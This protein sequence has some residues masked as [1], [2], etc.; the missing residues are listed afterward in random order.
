MEVLTLLWRESSSQRREKMDTP[1]KILV[2]ILTIAILFTCCVGGT[3]GFMY[4][5]NHGWFEIALGIT[6][7]IASETT[8]V[9]VVEATS[10]PCEKLE[11]IYNNLPNRTLPTGE[12][13][14]FRWYP[15]PLTEGQP[16]TS[17][18]VCEVE[19]LDFTSDTEIPVA[20][21]GG[22]LVADFNY[23][24]LLDNGAIESNCPR[25]ADCEGV[26]VANRSF[27]DPAGTTVH[28]Y[29][30]KAFAPALDRFQ[31][32][33]TPNFACEYAAATLTFAGETIFHDETNIRVP[34]WALGSG[35]IGNF[36]TG[37]H[38]PLP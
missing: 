29:V 13:L 7:P 19:I 24:H 37:Q 6:Q 23:G 1:T 3:F 16:E 18:V 32:Y 5:R 30:Y 26:W 28:L 21:G 15:Y 20:S 34:L 14:V 12:P 9:E 38:C 22:M 11:E 4:A 33:G 35:T 10:T 2:G 36:A 25:G 31:S 27:S 8:E 17:P